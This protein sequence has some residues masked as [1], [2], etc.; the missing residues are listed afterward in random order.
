MNLTPL[1]YNISNWAQATECLSNNSP[2]LSISVSTIT[3]RILSG[4]LISV[5]H[6]LYGTLFAA[7][8][9]GDGVIVS[10]NNGYGMPIT[11]MSTDEILA[12][13]AR[14]GFYITYNV[15]AHLPGDTLA[16]LMKLYNLGFDQISRIKVNPKHSDKSSFIAVVSFN[17]AAHPSWLAYPCEISYEEFISASS[18]G[19]AFNVSGISQFLG[20]DWSWLT[21]VA[22][23]S[24]VIRENS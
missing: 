23:I 20:I 3:D 11:W 12:Q 18:D 15:Q 9:S 21:F 6:V 24:D 13:L 19:T 14:F 7:M 2:D 17:G 4:Q 10:D 1:R 22:N 16:C 5:H 8:T